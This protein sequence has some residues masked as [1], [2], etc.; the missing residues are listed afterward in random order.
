MLPAVLLA[1]ALLP[2]S[3]AAGAAPESCPGDHGV[4]DAAFT[5]TFDQTLEGA[6]VMVPFEVPEGMTRVRVK[7]C[8]DQPQSPTNAFLRNTLDLGLYDRRDADGSFG[9]T[10]FRGWGGSSRPNVLITPT[11]ATTVGFNPGEIPAGEWGAE[12]G[13]AAVTGP[14]EGNPSGEVAWRLEVFH[15]FDDADL[16]NPWEPTPY[17]ESPARA[18]AGW[19][20][21]D[22][23]VHAEHSHPND[24]SMRETFDYAFAPRPEGAGL[25][26]ITLSDYVGDRAWDEIG[27][28]QGDY[29]GKLIVRS[30][31]VIT[32][33][34]HVNNHA[35]VTYVDH[36]TGPI[37]ELVGGELRLVREAQGAERIFDDI[38]AAG[39]TTQVNHPTTFPAFVPG[40]ANICRGCSWEYSDE[41]TNWNKVDAMEVQTGPSGLQQP[42]G[43]ELGPN[44][45]TPLAIEWWDR[46]RVEGY[47]ITAVGSSD[48]H[49]AGSPQNPITQSP[50]GHPTTVVFA[51]E[52]SEAGIQAALDAGHA[53]IKFF[54]SDGPD[55]R[56]EARPLDHPGRGRGPVKIMGDRLKSSEAELTAAV[57]GGGPSP[58][59]RT[60]FVFQDGEPI[61]TVPVS[62]D[63]FT[64]TFTATEPGH[65]RLQLQRGSTIEALTNPITLEPRPGPPRAR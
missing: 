42:E 16:Q 48:S 19:Y 63:D 53:Y 7:L 54:S 65:Y 61:A 38:L 50:I 9:A 21:G 32:Y 14:A 56:L 55:L 39:G 30:A 47:R 40:F 2:A 34:G 51:P 23:H 17:D 3:P 31:E 43:H 45:F 10:G 36:R 59:P 12:I 58:E 41:E 49:H 35:S 8:Y 37:Y 28:F 29:P 64:H 57:L 26:F 46:L 13:V 25:D 33:R 1:A 52:L 6:H 20:K 27:R 60:L 15:R 62:S 4:P 22:L 11:T 24:A 5:G 44:P 18:E